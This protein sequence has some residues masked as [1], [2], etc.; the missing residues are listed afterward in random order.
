MF[1]TIII[2]VQHIVI[3][4]Y[5]VEDEAK[6][7]SVSSAAFAYALRLMTR[8]PTVRDAACA[9]LCRMA[10]KVEGW[11][12]SLV[13]EL[14]EATAEDPTTFAALSIRCAREMEAAKPLR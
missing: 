14:R 8:D 10:P 11:T 12:S 2:Y 4:F 13:E 3:D 9:H 1:F 6:K 5:L 7:D